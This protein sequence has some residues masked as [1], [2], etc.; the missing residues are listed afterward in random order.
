MTL[1]EA[2][3]QVLA[4]SK[5]LIRAVDIA[6]VLNRTKLYAKKD[7]SPI[8]SSQIG[9][10]VKNYPHLFIKQDGLISLKST[11]G[12]RLVKKAIP[13]ESSISSAVAK[14]PSLVGKMLMNERNFKS[15]ADVIGHIPDEP[16]L[17]SIRIKDADALSGV[18]HTELIDRK[19]NI[20]YVGI[21]SKNLHKRLGQELWAKGHGTFFRSLGAMLGYR[22]EQGSLVGKA[23]QNNYKFSTTD[24]AK[25]IRWIEENILVNWVVTSEQL[26]ETEHQLIRQHLPLLNLAGNPKALKELTDARN[27]C[28]SVGRG[29]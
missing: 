20:L 19:H 27:E 15:V 11:T 21:A 14:N 5:Q 23:N 1:H 25:L 17:Y 18:F 10:R 9:A 12:V 29:N 24:E 13:K 26:K 2:I 3:E 16:G 6:N 7:G 4:S 22:P 8:K 28:K